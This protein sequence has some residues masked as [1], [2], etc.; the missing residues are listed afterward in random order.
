[1][2]GAAGRGR[3]VLA[4]AEWSSAEFVAPDDHAAAEARCV[5]ASIPAELRELPRWVVWRWGEI[6]ARTGKRKKPPYC[7]GRPD[8]H[9]SSTKPGTW[10]SFTDACAVVRRGDADGIGFALGPPYVGVD[11]DAELSEEDRAAVVR[12]LNSY[13]EWSVS[14]IG[15]HVI[16]RA[17]LNGHGRHPEGLGVFETAR[18]FYFTGE[19]MSGTPTTI[20]DRQEQLDEVLARFLPT[21]DVREPVRPSQPIDVADDELL[22]RAG[23]ARNCREFLRL[24]EGAWEGRYPSQSEADSALCTML[25]FWTGGDHDRV[26]RL[27]RRSGLMRAKWDSRRGES[28][29]GD[30]TIERALAGLTA[31][32][33]PP[34][35][36]GSKREPVAEAP[37]DE[38]NVAIRTN[39]T[40]LGNSERLVAEHGQDLRYSPGFG[41]LIWDGRRW[42]RDDDGAVTRAMADTVRGLYAEAAELDDDK[43]KRLIA[44]ALKSEQE[45]RLRAAVTLAATNRRVIV[46]NSEL[47][48]DPYLLSVCN[49]TVDLRT[50][51]LAEHSRAH[52][53][54]KAAP[55]EFHEHAEAP[56]WHAFLDRVFDN[57]S[58]L[59]QFVQRAV[60]YTLTGSTNEQVFF[61]AC[62]PGANGKTTFLET[63]RAVFGEYGQQTPTETFLERRDGIPND[64]ARLPGA[65][66]VAAAEVG[67]GRRLSEALVKRLTGGDVITARFLRAE[68]FEFTPVFK[69]WIATNHRPLIRGTDEAMWRRIRL[70]PFTVT[71]PESERDPELPAKL[72]AELSGILRWA[73]DGCLEWQRRGLKSAAAVTGATGSYRQ[74]MD[75]LGVFLD[76]CC[77]IDPEFK[78]PAGELYRAYREWCDESGERERLSQR[79]FADRLEERG[80]TASRTKDKRWRIG[81]RLRVTGD[82]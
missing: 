74:D 21:P 78:V 81:L 63:L 2:L 18:F 37:A 20:E 39:L 17:D 72:R 29:Y 73:V 46:R 55:V 40:D 19:H 44:H 34:S 36:L 67:E 13:A 10:G 49:G 66:F 50:G 16:V 45:G 58:E 24:Y 52:L 6:D 53:I 60:G 71:I 31:T 12:T 70:I 11:L 7:P 82:E 41:W 79:A 33:D 57:D 68:Y 22:A 47:D 65:R 26:D 15:C 35:Q 14:G 56:T 51:K 59:I 61:I 76:E 54:T 4:V 77:E 38:Q 80:F 5:R 69:A 27:F 30:V 3:E 62:G 9:A 8:Q 28:T 32:Y 42:R 64:L 25:G 1:M 23:R 48:A 75:V 43:R